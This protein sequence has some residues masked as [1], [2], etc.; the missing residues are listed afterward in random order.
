M[1]AVS[2]TR[3]RYDCIVIGGGHN[4]LSC[5]GFLARAGRSVLVLEASGR[6]GG[7]AVTREFAPGFRVS[8][9]AHL[10]HQMSAQ[11]IGE[12]EL[13]RHGLRWAAQALP[14]VALSTGAPLVLRQEGAGSQGFEVPADATAY[15]KFTE[16][17]RRFA[18]VLNPMLEAAPPKLGTDAWADRLNLLKL[19]WRI[20]RLG[21]RDM[22]ELLRIGGMNAFDLL[23]EHFQSP[24]LQG[25][26]ALD[27]VLGTNFG[28]R[29][30]GTVM[31]LLFRM[32][33]Q[34]G[35]GERGLALPV[36][37]LGAL[38]EALAA[39]AREAG[40]ETR[41]AAPVERVLVTADRA[42]GVRLASGES[43]AAGAVISSADP[44]TS[45]LALVGAEHFDAGFARRVSH[46][47]TRG[48]AAKLHL[49]LDGPPEFRDLPREA[50]GARLIVAPSLEYVE[51]A[52]NHS[53][54]GEYSRAP[55]LEIT[56]PTASDATLAPPGKHVLSA[57]VQ[58]A[59]YQITGGWAQERA[60]FT[61][62]I[63]DTL[64][65][66]APG[67]RSL[68]CGSE[69]LTPAD[70]EQEFRTL[71]GH[72]HHAEL[73]LDQFFAVRPVP[74]ATQHR[75]PLPGYYLCGA[76]CHPGGG[77]MGIAGRNAARQVISQERRT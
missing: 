6:L 43:I 47:R 62:Q 69:L 22:R 12:L 39:S 45:V 46:L 51:H 24:G 29:S 2:P 54:Y 5:A 38:S 9:G 34:H 55:A 60:A 71:G 75:T 44:N 15:L 3:T 13:E 58:Y 16:Q 42:C 14:T 53:K 27:A 68:V 30:P 25:A 50:Q 8:A 56:I 19:G 18:A 70:M 4:G 72:W 32:A 64:E 21:K 10:L 77:V 49:A 33:M 28:P 61:A 37:G 40:A 35:A 11:L 73:A 67:L 26:L 1:S 7:A 41:V 52:Y 57:I 74:G 31:T 65:R 48:L 63:I 17:M 23:T 76:G 20:R 36:G 59:P 66:Y